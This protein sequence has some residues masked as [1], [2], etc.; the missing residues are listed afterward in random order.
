[1]KGTRMTD[2]LRSRVE[3]IRRAHASARPKRENPAWWNT[4]HDLSIALQYIDQLLTDPDGEAILNG[5]NGRP[6]SVHQ[7]TAYALFTI[8]K[9]AGALSQDDVRQQVIAA[10]Q[11]GELHPHYIAILRDQLDDVL[12][13]ASTKDDDA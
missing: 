13:A 11:R 2:D 5:D 6:M 4:H 10:V 12:R 7:Q 8:G 1:M 3:Q 9:A